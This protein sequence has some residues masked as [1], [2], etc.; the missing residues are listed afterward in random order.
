MFDQTQKKI[1]IFLLTKEC[2][3][4]LLECLFFWQRV[5]ITFK[6]YETTDKQHT[7]DIFSVIDK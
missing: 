7:F 6:T 5:I 4:S 2:H 3:P 1:I